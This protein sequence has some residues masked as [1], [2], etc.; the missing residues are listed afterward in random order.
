M[1]PA[2]S[3]SSSNTGGDQQAKDNN[4]KRSGQIVLPVPKFK[5]FSEG[6]GPKQVNNA[7]EY[8]NGLQWL[9]IIK[10]CDAYVGLQLH[11]S[12]NKND[13]AWTCRATVKLSVVSCK[14][15]NEC[16]RQ[17]EYCHIFNA[18]EFFRDWNQFVKFEELMDPKN[19]LYDQKEDAVT[20]K[21]EVITEEPNG[22]AAVRLEDALLINGRVLYVNKHLLATHSTYFRTLFFGENAKEMPNIQIDELSDAFG[23]FQQVISHIMNPQNTAL[24]DEYVEGV[25][26]L[27]NRFLLGLVVNRCVEFLVTKSKKSAI[28]K[29]RLAHQYGI[30]GMKKKILKEMTKE[31][32]LIAGQNYMDNYA[33]NN[34][35][36]PE[37]LKELNERHK[38]LFGK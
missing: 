25:L 12:G 18:I 5:E 30:I 13:M 9:I 32:F 15:S 1:E 36:G 33:E 21:A 37:A 31:D 20:F 3:Q 29:F 16:L 22:M 24:Y 6:R 35:M 19:G 34:K 14:E 17:E 11:C 27:A 2:K 4:F 26:M 23:Y 7:W 8:I 28:C 38:E 10:H